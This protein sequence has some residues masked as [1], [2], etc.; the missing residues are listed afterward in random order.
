[1]LQ[2]QPLRGHGSTP[3]VVWVS[4]S[5]SAICF[6]TSHHQLRQGTAEASITEGLIGNAEG[7]HDGHE[8][9]DAVNALRLYSRKGLR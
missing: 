6:P 5:S 4:A 7:V 9:F 8:Q 3:V 1:L 2:D